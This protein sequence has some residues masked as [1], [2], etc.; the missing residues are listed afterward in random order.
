MG[1]GQTLSEGQFYSCFTDSFSLLGLL[2]IYG[3]EEFLKERAYTF[4]KK[5][6]HF[7]LDRLEWD[8]EK[9][10]Y[11]LKASLYESAPIAY[12]KNPISDRNCIERLFKDCIRAAEILNVDK[13]R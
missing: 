2:R 9:N 8:E 7:Y 12:V 6:S 4:M 5:A 10:E 3:S 13:E 1:K 11:F